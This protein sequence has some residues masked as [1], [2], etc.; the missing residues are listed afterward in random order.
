LNEP[1][2]DFPLAHQEVLALTDGQKP[3]QVVKRDQRQ[4]E[5]W[6]VPSVRFTDAFPGPVRVVRVRE[7]WTQRQRVGKQWK[8]EQ[9]EQNWIW[10][11]AGDLDGYDGSAIRD[12]G[13]SRWKI[14]NNAFGELTQQL[15]FDP[16]CPSSPGGGGGTVLDKNHRLHAFSCLCPFAW[17]TLPFR[18][19]LTQRGA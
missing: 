6:E 12:L 18:Q 11:V 14:E 5:I 3:T 19:S 7:R 10:V 4:V 1:P 13:H 2:N 17:Q 15:A 9:K 16:L 8:T